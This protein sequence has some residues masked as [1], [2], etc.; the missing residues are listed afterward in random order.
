MLSE[1]NNDDKSANLNEGAG[2]SGYRI[3]VNRQPY[4]RIKPGQTSAVGVAAYEEYE[5]ELEAENAPP[6]DIDTSIRRITLYPGNVAYLKYEARNSFAV[7]GRVVDHS[8]KPQA[9]VALRSGSART[10]A[11]INGNY[12]PYINPHNQTVI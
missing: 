6:Y 5:V 4:D 12:M 7:Y 2:D 3:K 11:A 8:G 10:P 1:I 9:N